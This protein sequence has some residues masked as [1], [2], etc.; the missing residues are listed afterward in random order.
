MGPVYATP[1]DLA[2]WLGLDAPP[3]GAARALRDASLDVDVLLVGAVY[4]VND[5]GA[6]TDPKAADVLKQATLYQCEHGTPALS[7]G[8]EQAKGL[9]T[10]KIDGIAYTRATDPAT[11]RIIED[12]MSDRAMGLLWVEGLIPNHPMAR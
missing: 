12:R 8:Q 5:E 11:G 9:K 2:D 7:G 1:T 10:V 6:P 4:A 3:E